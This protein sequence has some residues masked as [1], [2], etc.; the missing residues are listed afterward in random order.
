MAEAM[1]RAFSMAVAMGWEILWPLIL[2]LALSAVVQAIVSHK[3]LSQL[4]PDDRPRSIAIAL[5]LGAVS[6]SCSY[7]VAATARS[8]SARACR[9]RSRALA[10]KST[11]KAAW[12]TRGG[13]SKVKDL[14]AVPPEICHH[15]SNI[16]AQIECTGGIT[17]KKG[18]LLCHAYTSFLRPWSRYP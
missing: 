12:L 8:L 3:E 11:V 7:A 1:M 5:T 18:P 2:G 14:L 17:P 13:Y 15:A 10:I 4:M 9:G 16:G 6:P